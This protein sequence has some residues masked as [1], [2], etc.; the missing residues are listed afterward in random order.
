MSVWLCWWVGV[1]GCRRECWHMV[2]CV[3]VR[4]SVYGC[5]SECGHMV[6]CVCVRVSGR[7][8]ACVC[9]WVLVF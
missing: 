6:V 7:V 2:V 1:Y 4:V 3:V 8:C 9:V 5:R